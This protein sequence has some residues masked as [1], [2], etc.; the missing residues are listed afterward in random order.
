MTDPVCRGR[1]RPPL[2]A[3]ALL[4]WATVCVWESLV[5][6][7]GLTGGSSDGGLHED[8]GRADA[9]ADVTVRDVNTPDLTVFDGAVP[10]DGSDALEDGGAPVDANFGDVYVSPPGAD[11]ARFDGCVPYPCDAGEVCINN[12]NYL[13]KTN[14]WS[15]CGA[16]AA[17]CEPDPGCLCIVES[18]S[19]WCAKPTCA[20][21]G[22]DFQLTCTLPPPP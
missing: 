7:G 9:T 21:K 12:I 3:G 5:A 4:C 14:E 11:A 16:I 15:N 17:G 22:S 18:Y 8:Q 19:P 13:T 2:H 10:S 1:R 6:C 20:R